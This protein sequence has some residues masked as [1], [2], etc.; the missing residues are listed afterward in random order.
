MYKILLVMMVLTAGCNSQFA[1]NGADAKDFMA[2]C[3]PDS[4]PAK[5]APCITLLTQEQTTQTPDEFHNT[6][7]YLKSR[8][9]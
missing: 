2:I 5:Q 8:K 9:Q 3:N 7:L 4:S 6:V 1:L